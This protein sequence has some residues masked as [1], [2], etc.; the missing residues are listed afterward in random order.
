[1]AD[2]SPMMRQYRAIKAEHRDEI[3]F[4]RLGDFYEMFTEDALEVSSLLNLTLTSRNG[5]PMCGVPWHASRNYMARLLKLGKKIAVCEQVS[6]PAASKTLVE[7]RV[8]ERVSPGTA[9]D[10]AFL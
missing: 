7:R 3:L 9:T 1:M 5:V 10:E 6:D 8:V 2:D 4:F